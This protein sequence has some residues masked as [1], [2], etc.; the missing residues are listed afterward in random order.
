MEEIDKLYDAV[1]KLN[2]RVSELDQRNIEIETILSKFPP[3][4]QKEDSYILDQ[5]N[6]VIDPYNVGGYKNVSMPNGGVIKIKSKSFCANGRHIIENLEKILFCAKCN[7]ILC[8]EHYLGV[9]GE[10]VCSNC[11]KNELK[12]IDSLSLY[13]LAAISGGFSLHKLK[14][15]LNVE[16]KEFGDS[17][18]FLLSSKYIKQNLL[19][20]Y[21]LTIHG[22][23]T[24]ALAENLYDFSFLYSYKN[25]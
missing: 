7:A 22:R 25:D 10:P 24:L 20:S 17:L 23:H 15:L 2:K 19:F 4:Q 18:S 5:E 12:N 14:K 8:A 21:E 1:I 9:D 13:I 11:I 16:R 6:T 3:Q